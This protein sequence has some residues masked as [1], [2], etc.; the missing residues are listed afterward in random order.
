MQTHIREALLA[1]AFSGWEI[2]FSWKSTVLCVTRNQ[3][4]PLLWEVEGWQSKNAH[5]GIL[6]GN[7][8]NSVEPTI[9]IVNRIGIS[10]VHTRE[11]SYTLHKGRG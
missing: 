9:L 6:F 3:Q 10:K 11:I 7:P 5:P 1:A 4:A 2:T 8:G